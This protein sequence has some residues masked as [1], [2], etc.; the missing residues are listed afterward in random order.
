MGWTCV[1]AAADFKSKF[2]KVK[3]SQ[4]VQKETEEE[5]KETRVKV[6]EDRKWQYASCSLCTRWGQ[7]G[8]LLGENLT[9]QKTAMRGVVAE[10]YAIQE[11]SRDFLKLVSPCLF[12]RIICWAREGDGFSTS[13]NQKH[14]W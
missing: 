9:C 4:I 14:V 3:V 12:Q 7:P 2:T 5:A 10:I 13:T 6:D 1:N 8:C 11:S